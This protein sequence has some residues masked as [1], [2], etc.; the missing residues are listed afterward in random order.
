[1][2]KRKAYLMLSRGKLERLEERRDEASVVVPLAECF[3]SQQ[4]IDLVF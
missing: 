3:K 2:S 1:M 4:A